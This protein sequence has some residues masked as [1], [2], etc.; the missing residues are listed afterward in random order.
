MTATS[1]SNS[2]LLRDSA[3]ASL[4][5]HSEHMYDAHITGETAQ[6]YFPWSTLLL[7]S[8]RFTCRIGLQLMFF[9][10]KGSQRESVQAA[11]RN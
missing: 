4:E 1:P 3:A 5:A 10:D 6:V 9:L 11:F 7:Q 8:G 2:H